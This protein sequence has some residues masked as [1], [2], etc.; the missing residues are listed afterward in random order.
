MSENGLLFCRGL[1]CHRGSGSRH[2]FSIAQ[3]FA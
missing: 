1:V 3:E 2:R